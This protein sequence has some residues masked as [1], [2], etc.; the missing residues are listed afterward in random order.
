MAL[1]IRSR[2]LLWYMLLLSIFY[3]VVGTLFFHLHRASNVMDQLVNVRYRVD[4]LCGKLLEAL[5]SMEENEKKFKLL[6]KAHYAELFRSAARSFQG[7]LR[8][9]EVL[10]QKLPEETPW[11]S[12]SSQMQG[13]SIGVYE[14]EDSEGFWLTEDLAEQWMG[15]IT[16]F[17][18]EN[19]W[20]VEQ[21]LRELHGSARRA[22]HW[23]T[24]GLLGSLGTGVLGLALLTHSVSR[25]L[26]ALKRGIRSVQQVGQIEPIAV[27]SR[28]EL[29]DVAVAFNEMANRLREEER[30]RSDFIAMLSHEIR[31]PLTSIAESVNLVAEEVT[32]PINERQRRLLKIARE[33][34]GRVTELLTQLM[35]ISRMESGQ[36]ELRPKPL[37]PARVVASCIRRVQPLA[38]SSGVRMSVNMRPEVPPVMADEAQIQQVVLNLLANAVKFSAPGQEVKVR[39]EPDMDPRWV[40]FSV[41]DRGRGIPEEEQALVFQKYYR[42]SGDSGT[43]DGMGL[44]LSISRHIVEAHGGTMGLRSKP[45]QGSCFFFT[46]PRAK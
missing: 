25:P 22:Q 32:G 28:D 35:R 43:P 7:N 20:R 14:H 17:R 36:L 26:R 1:S 44:G 23:S 3:G 29:G 45:G 16:R 2:F 13:M 8:E 15:K 31:T 6:K 30:M 40:R 12:M 34:M 37:D 21:E 5:L 42:V 33:E 46:M 38:E 4:N 18:V 9:L 41:E 19:Q 10:G 11:G 24:V 27:K 39:V